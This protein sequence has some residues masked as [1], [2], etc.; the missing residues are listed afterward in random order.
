MSART[1]KYA[2]SIYRLLL[3]ATEAGAQG[4]H[5]STI[6]CGPFQGCRAQLVFVI[7]YVW[8]LALQTAIVF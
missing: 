6:R 8:L 7:S 5:E 3:G 4:Q 2:R 1:C